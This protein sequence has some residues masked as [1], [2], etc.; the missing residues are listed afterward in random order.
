[1]NKF[2]TRETRDYNNYTIMQLQSNDKDEWEM[3]PPFSLDTRHISFY[4]LILNFTFR[5]YC[6][7]EIYTIKSDTITQNWIK[8][9]QNEKSV[10]MTWGGCRFIKLNGLTVSNIKHLYINYGTHLH[11]EISSNNYSIYRFGVLI[12]FIIFLFPYSVI[13]KINT[14]QALS[15]WMRWSTNR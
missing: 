13:F 6:K 9:R 15:W 4:Y 10:K 8:K 11:E 7:V 14:Y 1:M 12:Y 2:K 5:P 3:H